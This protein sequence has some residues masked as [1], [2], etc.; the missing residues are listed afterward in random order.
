MP[1]DVAGM[2]FIN[3]QR[4]SVVPIAIQLTTGSIGIRRGHFN[5]REAVADEIDG[6]NRA[7]G[8]ENAF[9][10]GSLRRIRKVSNQ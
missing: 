1:R 7:D 3:H 5:K 2:S 9:D 4:P 6:E 10:D 8:F